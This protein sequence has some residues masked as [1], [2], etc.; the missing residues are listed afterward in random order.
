MAKKDKVQQIQED[1]HK[2]AQINDSRYQKIT[3]LIDE[4][5]ER[6]NGRLERLESKLL[7]KSNK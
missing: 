5:L 1:L 4:E 6:I 3:S 7:K 2:L